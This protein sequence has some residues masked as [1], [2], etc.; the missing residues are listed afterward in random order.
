MTL[1]GII[2][3]MQGTPL[4]LSR[5]DLANIQG[6]K[7]LNGILYRCVESA[8]KTKL[9]FV[10][11]QPVRKYLAVRYY[12][13][14]GHSGVDKVVQLI[15]QTF[16]FLK[17][18]NYVSQHTR[19]CVNCT[20]VKCLAERQQGML[21]PIPPGQ[22]PFAIIHIDFLGPFVPSSR[23]HSEL[24]VIV[25]NFTKFIRLRSCPSCST[26]YVLKYLEEFVNNFGWPYCV[27]TDRGRCFTASA[28]VNFCALNHI[29]HTLN[30]SQ[31]PQ[32]NG[33]VE[34]INPI[35]ISLVT[36][37]S[38]VLQ[39]DGDKILNVA[40]KCINWCPSK[41]TGKLPFEMLYGYIPTKHGDFPRDLVPEENVMH[42]V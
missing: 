14:S 38:T 34:R 23:R 39:I 21:N 4:L 17:M 5:Q 18:K 3:R 22:R 27:I 30:S 10:M 20:F 37:I 13:F 8:R 2:Q 24:L 11:P 32:S 28:F 25:D 26:V 33:Q 16:W 1:Q 40:Q 41:S 6:F 19:Q 12:D 42:D 15:H 7:L 35:L 29:R 36:S 31:R 9:L